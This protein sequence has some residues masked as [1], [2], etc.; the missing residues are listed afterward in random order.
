M[1]SATA[2]TPGAPVQLSEQ[3]RSRLCAYLDY[4]LNEALIA[5]E[6]LENQLDIWNK[7]YTGEPVAKRKD[8]PWEN[9]CNVVI[10]LIGIHTDSIVARIVNTMFSVEPFWTARP[11]IKTLDKVAKPLEDFLEWSR[12]QEFDLYNTVRTWTL[13]VTKYGWGY[14]KVPWD[15]STLRTFKVGPGG[16]IPVEKVVRRPKPQHVLLCDIICQVG[17]EDELNQAEWLA[18][19]VRLTD[20]ELLWREYD[21]IYDNVEDILKVKEDITDL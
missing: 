5:H 20:G 19:R 18:H 16:A 1:S 4:E 14:I 2:V 7:A 17:I 10:P 9:A 21:G 3:Q 15:V 6:Q 11:L 8:F 12:T 13:E